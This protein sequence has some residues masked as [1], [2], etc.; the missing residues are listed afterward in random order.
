MG[1][2]I[3]QLVAYGVQDIFLTGDPQ[4]TF[5]K[6]VYKRYTNFSIEPIR[7]F[8]SSPL[9]FGKRV[10][11]TIARQGDLITN[12]YLYIQLPFVPT[13]KASDGQTLDPL[14]KFAWI[15]K[16]G[17]GIIDTID[18]EIGGQLLDRHYGDWLNIWSELTN[19]HKGLDKMIGNIDE[20]T[21][22]TNGK[23]GYGLYIPLQFWF[24]KHSGLALPIVSLQ[25]SE[26]K[27]H[28][29][30]KKLED[31]II[32]SPTHSVKIT[33]DVVGFQPFE[34]IEQNVNGVITGAIFIDYDPITQLLYYTKINDNPEKVMSTELN[35]I[36]RITGNP[37]TTPI[38]GKIY[39]VNPDSNC[40]E[41]RLNNQ[42]DRQLT[43]SNGWLNVTYIYLDT[44]ER[45]RFA[46]SNHEFLIEQL[47]YPGSKT[48][49]N[50]S[51]LTQLSFNHPV[52]EVVWVAQLRNLSEGFLNEQFN[53]SND[54]VV[55]PVNN[56]GTNIIKSST[57][58]L[59]GH[60]RFQPRDG[61]YFNW[62]VPYEKHT[63]GPS[64]GIYVYAFSYFPEQV[65]QP[66]GSCNMSKIDDIKL[67]IQFDGTV[68]SCNL[69][70]LRVYMTNYNVFRIIHGLGGVA[71]SS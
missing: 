10:T 1:G 52:K 7:Q 45:L 61:D 34:Y 38:C 66:S 39:K 41:T 14:R 44:E 58:V 16:I 2:G 17:Y 27:I 53:Y 4:I 42:L 33:Q 47:Q 9:D 23:Q 21:S 50:N 18:I 62:V 36:D 37:V 49:F 8:F 56:R 63:V 31:C 22:Y 29:E 11:C 13:F 65:E 71:F 19:V 5:F 28:V 51:S 54:Y 15:K 35:T 40:L 43:I 69:V 59:N 30:L 3:I 67:H 57:I 26:I 55:D 70:D 64:T 12:T 46:K 32:T 20:L 48:I 25:Y 6:T 24:C 68:N 60:D